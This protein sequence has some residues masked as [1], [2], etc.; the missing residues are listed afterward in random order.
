[1]NERLNGLVAYWQ[2]LATD[3]EL[4]VYVTPQDIAEF[5]RRVRAEGERFLTVTL[6]TLGKAMEASF[7]TG[8]LELP[9]GFG[10]CGNRAYPAFLRKAFEELYSSEGVLLWYEYSPNKLFSFHTGGSG[11][12]LAIRQLTLMCYKLRVPYQPHQLSSFTAAFLATESEIPDSVSSLT[13]TGDGPDVD[14]V[15][16]VASRYIHAVLAG[17]N[18]LDIRPKHGSGQSACKTLPWER[19]KRPRFVPQLHKLYPQWEWFF[20]NFSHYSEERA[21]GQEILFHPTSRL[22]F[23]PKD[24]RGPRVICMEPRELMFVQQGQMA[25]MYKAIQR[26]RSVARE[27]SCLTQ[28]PNRDLAWLG[29]A[30]GS[31]AT[32]DLK[33]ASDRVSL[34]L[35]RALFPSNWWDALTA[36]R[37]T[38]CELP[39]GRVIALKKFAPMGSA[40]CF[41]VE[42]LVFWAICRGVFDV[43]DGRQHIRLHSRRALRVFGDDLVL[44]QEM[45]STVISILEVVGLK[46]NRQ[47]SYLQGP[48]RE[49]CGADFYEGRDVSIVRCKAAF[50]VD[51]WGEKAGVFRIRDLFNETIRRFGMH[52]SR[53]LANLLYEITGFRPILTARW[54][55]GMDHRGKEVVIPPSG[56]LSLISDVTDVSNARTRWDDDYQCRVVRVLQERAVIKPLALADRSLLLKWELTGSPEHRSDRVALP[57]RTKYKYGWVCL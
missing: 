19:W 4:S 31:L 46:V 17:V 21:K 6:P 15:L 24:S 36:S 57:K 30:T 54:A 10:R 47:K 39:D 38:H 41:P 3:T 40:N 13:L 5:K 48:F 53:P 51:T 23:V 45:A 56:S 55:V 43:V 33:E 22:T 34:E 32:L 18:P 35:V 29:S 16:R 50:A 12:V 42:S 27:V 37:S 7:A 25:L 14:C 26:Y 49:S 52:L 9:A 2:L 11:A 1:M 8:V 44:P 28:D 20:W